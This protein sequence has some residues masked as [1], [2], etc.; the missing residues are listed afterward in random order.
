MVKILC[1]ETFVLI[2]LDRNT[3]LVVLAHKRYYTPN[4]NSVNKYFSFIL[5]NVTL[6]WYKITTISNSKT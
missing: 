3:Y 5:G 6:F 1:K 2:F 4:N